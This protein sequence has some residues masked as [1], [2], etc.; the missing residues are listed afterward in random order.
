MTHKTAAEPGL[1]PSVTEILESLSI[2]DTGQLYDAETKYFALVC[3][4]FHSF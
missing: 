3:E 2:S 1:C 4:K